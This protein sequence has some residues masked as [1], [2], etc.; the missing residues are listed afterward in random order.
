MAGHSKWANIKHR[1][2]A[3]DK[4]KA[5]IFSR[6]AKEIII[7]VKTGGGPDQSSNV[8]LRSALIAARA[9]NMPNANIDRSIKKAVGDV[10]GS[11][12]EE[13]TYE[14]YGAEGVAILVE[15]LT[16]NRNR[17]GGDVRMMFD[18]NNGNMA[19]SGAVT[20]MFHRN[21]HFVVSG[22][23]ASEDKL[24]D[25]VLD[26]GAEDIEVDGE[27]AEIL[28]APEA[29]EDISKALDNAGI[30]VDE[31]RITRR[32]ENAIKVESLSAARSILKLI[33][34]LEDLDD[35]QDVYANFDFSNELLEELAEED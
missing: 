16:D 34:K 29:F 26:A 4:K 3:A 9:A 30:S 20:W 5:K 2:G 10:D 22:E 23:N 8:R 1:K 18:R 19:S 28:G 25:I 7:A 32:P 35:V 33:E 13:I 11:N 12:Y 14:G 21:A 6:L 31:A 15:C 27:I 24:M 17:S